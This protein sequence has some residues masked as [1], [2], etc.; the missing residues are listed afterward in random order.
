MRG[1]DGDAQAR[2]QAGSSSAAD[3]EAAVCQARAGE[4][5]ARV[6]PDDCRLHRHAREGSDEAGRGWRCRR[7]WWRD[8]GVGTCLRGSGGHAIPKRRRRD[9]AVVN[10][11]RSILEPE[12]KAPLAG[13]G[14]REVLETGDAGTRGLLLELACRAIESAQLV[15]NSCNRRPRFGR[16]PPRDRERVA[17]T[18][19]VATINDNVLRNA[20]RTIVDN[21]RV[22]GRPDLIPGRINHGHLYVMRPIAQRLGIERKLSPRLVRTR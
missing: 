3:D 18:P 14:D 6:A 2:R 16:I 4:P 13:G 11:A 7:K 5:E 19:R 12:P 20:R 22:R 8:G 15:M 21:D 10:V 9:A 1:S 17:G